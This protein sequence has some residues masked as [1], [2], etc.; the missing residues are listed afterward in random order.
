MWVYFWILFCSIDLYV[1]FYDNTMGFWLLYLCS[2]VFCTEVF[3]VL[4]FPGGS[5]GKQS[6]RSV[7]D[8]GLIPG[9]ERS[10]GE[11]N[12][13][14]LQCSC[15]EN[16]MDRGT[17]WATVHGVT[18]NLRLSTHILDIGLIYSRKKYIYTYTYIFKK[19]NKQKNSLTVSDTYVPPQ[20]LISGHHH[21]SLGH[22]EL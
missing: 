17:W 4:S 6:A 20:I 9:S 18:K 19:K 5:D 16:P 22:D 2:T 11:E 14:P 12:G 1:C 21:A 7:G 13:Y 3:L 15:L 10:P 8:Q